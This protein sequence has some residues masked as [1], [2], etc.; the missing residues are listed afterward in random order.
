MKTRSPFISLAR[1]SNTCHAVSA[2]VGIAA[3]C[4]YDNDEGL[5]AASTTIHMKNTEY[6]QS[7]YRLHGIQHIQRKHQA[8]ATLQILY[9]LVCAWLLHLQ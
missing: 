8:F 2:T 4:T 9:H 3:A 6:I 1:S 7:S 5:G